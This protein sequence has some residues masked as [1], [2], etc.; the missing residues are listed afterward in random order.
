[1]NLS[2]KLKFAECKRKG[3]KQVT[4]SE[5]YKMNSELVRKK[6]TQFKLFQPRASRDEF[7]AFNYP[8]QTEEN[9]NG[10]KE[11]RKYIQ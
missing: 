10:I 5:H 9:V 1:M 6:Y 11:H 7:W 2:C 8:I 4:A 3:E